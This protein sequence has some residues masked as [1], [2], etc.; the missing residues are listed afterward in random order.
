[1]QS[2]RRKKHGHLVEDLKIVRHGQ[3]RLWDVGEE[4]SR[5]SKRQKWK[6]K[7]YVASYREAGLKHLKD[8]VSH[9]SGEGKIY[10]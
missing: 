8:S 7:Q 5:N 9:P 2:L 6:N 3:K 4:Q 1:M 10:K